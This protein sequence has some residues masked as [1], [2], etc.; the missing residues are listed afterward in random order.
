M[1]FGFSS[2]NF[3]FLGSHSQHSWKHPKLNVW[4]ALFSTCWIHLNVKM[5]TSF[6]PTIHPKKQVSWNTWTLKTLPL[7][8]VQTSVGSYDLFEIS[9]WIR[10]F[11][12][13][14]VY[15]IRI[16]HFYFYFYFRYPGWISDFHIFNP[17]WVSKFPDI[18]HLFI[19]RIL[20]DLDIKNS[21]ICLWIMLGASLFFG[22]LQ[23]ATSLFFLKG[24]FC[25]KFNTCWTFLKMWDQMKNYTEQINSHFTI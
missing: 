15:R 8:Q 20:V 10:I 23:T 14:F 16:L 17:T 18:C 21:N 19:S 22:D 7:W 24:I 25:P 5:A 6:A 12:F 1:C 9:H 11:V 2:S 3:K 4:R 13:S